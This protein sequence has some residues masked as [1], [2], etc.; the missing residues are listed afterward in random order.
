MNA[1]DGKMFTKF[2]TCLFDFTCYGHNEM[3]YSKRPII[4]EEVE[5]IETQKSTKL[6]WRGGILFDLPFYFFFLQKIGQPIYDR[7]L[8]AEE[9]P[10]AFEELGRQIQMYM[11]I[12]ESYKAKVI[13]SVR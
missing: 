12:V 1:L 4:H 7:Y 2:P 8:E 5:R 6:N 3:S 10:K 13:I 9:R 11:K